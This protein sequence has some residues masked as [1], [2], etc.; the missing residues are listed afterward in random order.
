MT[1]YIPKT[2]YIKAHGDGAV[3]TH[4]L[5]ISRT[6]ATPVA[7]TDP[8]G[9]EEPIELYVKL[10]PYD[11]LYYCSFLQSC[12]REPG[13]KMPAEFAAAMHSALYD[14]LQMVDGL[15][16]GDRFILPK[17][18]E[19]ADVEF[20]VVSYHVVRVDKPGDFSRGVHQA[21]SDWYGA[22]LTEITRMVGVFS[23]PD[24]ALKLPEGRSFMNGYACAAENANRAQRGKPFVKEWPHEK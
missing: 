6:A 4:S 10:D 23:E 9:D 3:C 11:K 24:A 12:D 17:D 7:F 20:R 22:G 19:R 14:T 8:Y 16:N 15:N 13:R 21:V 18:S 1:N 2:Y 5:F